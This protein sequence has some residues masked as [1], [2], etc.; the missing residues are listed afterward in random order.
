VGGL[1]S[2]PVRA[3]YLYLAKYAYT[4]PVVE[5]DNVL[6]VFPYTDAMQRPEYVQFLTIPSGT[7]ERSTDAYGNDVRRAFV[8]VPHTELIFATAGRALLRRRDEMPEDVPLGGDVAP[9]IAEF[10]GPSPLVHPFQVFDA[11]REVTAGQQTLLGAVHAIVWWVHANVE[12]KR[13]VTDIG[14]LSHEVLAG[15][16][17]VCQDFTHLSL[18]ML[19]TLGVPCRYCSGLLTEERG[20]THA[21]LE[22]WHPEDGWITS[23]PTRGKPIVTD[24]ELIKFAVGRDYTDVAPV[25]GAFKAK[26]I[27]YLD[28]LVAEARLEMATPSIEEALAAMKG[29]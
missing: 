2:D 18:A 1:L 8:D 19:R 28:T 25:V 26:G 10:A 24:A 9:E 20:E 22:F 14:T 3:S 27:G 21:W 23:D 11:A 4:Q 13:G 12:Y 7:E 6:R 17:G 5:N 29:D 15:R 16:Q